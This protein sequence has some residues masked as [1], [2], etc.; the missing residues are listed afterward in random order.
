VR[1]LALGLL[2]IAAAMVASV[3]TGG[4][5]AYPWC[6]I[7]QDQDDGWA[8]GFETFEKCRVEARSGNTGFCAP[9]PAYQA[10]AK[11]ARS[12]KRRQAK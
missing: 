12:H 4:A 6:M 1:K 10:P 11:P 2:A 5:K 3:S 7:I 9:N 8:C